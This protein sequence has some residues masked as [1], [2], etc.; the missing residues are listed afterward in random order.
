M[1]KLHVIYCFEKKLG[2]FVWRGKQLIVL[3]VQV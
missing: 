3:I 2:E 1:S